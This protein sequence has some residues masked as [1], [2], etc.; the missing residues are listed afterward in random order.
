[1]YNAAKNPN[2]MRK[3]L[4]VGNAPVKQVFICLDNTRKCPIYISTEAVDLCRRLIRVRPEAHG[5]L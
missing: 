2:R 1:M 3:S 5:R 4:D